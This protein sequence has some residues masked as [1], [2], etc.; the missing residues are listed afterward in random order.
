[1][2][3]KRYKGRYLPMHSSLA[4]GDHPDHGK[5]ELIQSLADGALIVKMNT[6]NYTIG[7]H[8]VMD[9]FFEALSKHLGVPESM[10]GKKK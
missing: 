6:A 9:D 8:A 10:T 1:M 5:F 7:L 2:E 4:E 3:I